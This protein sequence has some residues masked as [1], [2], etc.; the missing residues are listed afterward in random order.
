MYEFL[1]LP[2]ELLVEVLAQLDYLSIFAVRMTCRKLSQIT[3]SRHLWS[4]VISRLQLEH[5]LVPPE[6][7]ISNYSIEQLENWTLRRSTA[8][9]VLESQQ[10]AEPHIRRLDLR[11]QDIDDFVVPVPYLLP[12]GQWFL[13]AHSTSRMLVYDLDSVDPARKYLFNPLDFDEKLASEYVRYTFWFDYSSPCFTFYVAGNTF[14][15]DNARS[16]IYSVQLSGHGASATPT[17]SFVAAFRSYARKG[18]YMGRFAL[19]KRYYVEVRRDPS[20]RKNQDILAYE[21]QYASGSSDYCSIKPAAQTCFIGDQIRLAAFIYDNVLAICTSRGAIRLFDIVGSESTTGCESSS[22]FKLLHTVPFSYDF[23]SDIQWSPLESYVVSITHEGEF[24]GLRVPH[25][26]SIPPTVLELGKHEKFLNKTS[27][28]KLGTSVS[29]FLS[30]S[31]APM[32]IVHHP[33]INV[34]GGS[35]L[36]NCLKQSLNGFRVPDLEIQAKV[37]AFSEDLGRFV[38]Y[39]DGSHTSIVVVDFTAPRYLHQ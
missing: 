4:R 6:E 23:C 16:F 28:W 26:R 20:D 1:S 34:R 31:S 8:H 10:P 5:G 37:I 3:R 22:T 30:A 15:K 14:N 36:L 19:N 38:I 29:T 27:G 39:D 35:A 12:G 24:K 21:F 18:W 13:L 9:T 17:A 33:W 32:E 2:T 7:G 11:T 25:D